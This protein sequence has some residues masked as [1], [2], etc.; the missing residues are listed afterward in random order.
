MQP[1][2]VLVVE[3]N[4][5][6]FELLKCA[7]N[8]SGTNFRLGVAR[9]GVEAQEYLLGTGKFRDRDEAP[10][11]DLMLLDLH[12]PRRSGFEVL[13]WLRGQA[14]SLK[15]LPVIVLTS[16]PESKDVDRAYALG[17]NSY[18]VK[19]GEVGKMVAVVKSIAEYADVV[20]SGARPAASRRPKSERPG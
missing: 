16:S 5:A 15:T 19:E 4:P 6:D 17:A 7:F 2:T 13:E 12:L 18:L 8:R 14:S 20:V 3:D 11:P 10:V 1:L 9:D